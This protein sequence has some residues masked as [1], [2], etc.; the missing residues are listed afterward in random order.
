MMKSLLRAALFTTLAAS[1]AHAQEPV[2]GGSLIVR[3]NSDIRSLEPGINRDA[4]TDTV[5]HQIF[6]GLVA[7]QADLT[8][9]PALAESWTISEDGKT[10][11]FKLRSGVTFHNGAPL[12]SAEVKWSWDRQFTQAAWTCKRL[13]DDNQGLKVEALET[14]APDTVVYKLARPNALFLKQ[15]ANIQCGIL[16]SHPRSVEAEGKWNPI[17]TGPLKLKEWKRGEA[18]T[19]E[20]F[21]NYSA[22]KAPPSGYAGA[23]IMNFDQ[24]VFRVVPDASAAEAALQT[25]AVDIL[26]DIE[27]DRVEELKKRKVAISTKPG[28][29]FAAILIQ[30]KD[31]L[32]SN[33][34]LRLALAHAIDREQIAEVRSSGLTKANPS[35]VSDSSSYYDES[36]MAWPDYDPKKAQALAKEAG[37]AGQTLKIQTNKRYTSMYDN[38]VLTQAM[39]TQAGFK[40][41]LEVL[42]WATQLDNYL[43]GNFQL[44]SFGYSARFDPTQMYAAL[45]AE[46]DKNP[47]AQW[48]DPQAITILA[49][50][51]T[52]LDDARRKEDFRKLH[53]MMREQIPIVGLY[54]DPVIEAAHPRV[55]N[56]ASW[57]PGKTITWGAWKEK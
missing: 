27:S 7:F 15:L 53:A 21:A 51:G 36:F 35:G 22:S 48:D 47:W 39:L 8:V 24:V 18:I 43:K 45:I 28:L 30:T 37:Y 54:Y 29:G 40:V 16:V 13:F 56:Y 9:G 31:P 33:Q 44:Q 14:P 4:Q 3:L 38:A 6:E 34:K 11:T 32:L 55:K 10:Y 5:A 19:L 52:V 26:P 17:G 46:K 20:R 23:R 50:S 49:D 41:E 2:R 57:A 12:T 1:F 42:D 25:G